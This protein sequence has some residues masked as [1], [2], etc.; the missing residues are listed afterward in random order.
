MSIGIS[1]KSTLGILDEGF[2]YSGIF[3]SIDVLPGEHD[4][5]FGLYPSKVVDGKLEFRR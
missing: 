4:I 3:E 2:S 5:A 1:K